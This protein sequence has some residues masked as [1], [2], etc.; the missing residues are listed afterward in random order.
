MAT[1]Y[2]PRSDHT[3]EEFLQDAELREQLLQRGIQQLTK[4]EGVRVTGE[5]STMCAA[6]IDKCSE[7]VLDAIRS[8]PGFRVAVEKPGH[9]VYRLALK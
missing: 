8:I 4:I 6:V 5:L 2:F 9:P 1:V 7:E 3:R